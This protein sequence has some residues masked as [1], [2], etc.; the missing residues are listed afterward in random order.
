MV[1]VD[2]GSGFRSMVTVFII[3]YVLWLIVVAGAVV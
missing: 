1:S 2:T 3:C